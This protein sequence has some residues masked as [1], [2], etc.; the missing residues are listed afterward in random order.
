MSG[1]LVLEHNNKPHHFL[2]GGGEMGARMRSFDWTTTPLG[3]P[4]SWPQSLKTIIRVMLDSRY[5]MWMLWGAENTFFCNDAYL[6]TVGIRRDWVL[7]ARSDLVWEEV[8]SEVIVPRLERV[9]KYGEATWDEA[10]QLFL[11]RSGFSE[12]TYHT[13]SYSPIYDDDNRIAGMLCVVTEVTD[14]VIGERRLRVL[15]ELAAHTAAPET[16]ESN[17]ARVCR[18]LDN[19]RYDIAFSAIYL[20]EKNTNMARRV[21]LSNALEESVAPAALNADTQT[22]WPLEKLIATATAQECDLIAANISVRSPLWP[23][24]VKKALLVPFKDAGQSTLAGFILVG[25]SPRRPFDD[26]YHSFLELVAN[27]IGAAVAEA[28][29]YAAERRRLQALAELDRAKTAFF[30]NVS[31]EFRTPLT[32]MLSPVETLLSGSDISPEVRNQLELAHRNSLRL[33]KLVNSLLDFSRIEAGRVD[34]NF[35]ATDFTAFARDIASTFRSAIERAGLQFNVHCEELPQPVYIDRDMWEK[36]ILNLLSNAFKFTLQGSIEVRLSARENHALLEV[37]DTGVG[38]PAEELS[39]LF[40]RFYRVEK[41]QGRTHEGSGIGLALVRELVELHGAEIQVTSELGVGSVFRIA[42]PFGYRHLPSDKIV[43]AAQLSSAPHH[44]REFVEEALRW[45]P[46]AAVDPTVNDIDAVRADRR[47]EKTFGARI[48]VVD[49]NADMRAYMRTLLSPFY[50]V[51]TL[52]DGVEALASARRLRPDVILSDVMMPNL[53]GFGLLAELH[54]DNQLRDVPVILLSARA[55]EEARIEGFDAGADD[56]LAKPF[57]SREMLMCV[58]ALLE[59]THMRRDSES[60]LRGALLRSQTR[61]AQ[62]ETLLSEAPIGIFLL[63]SDLRF[64]EINPAGFA[65]FD[66][67]DLLIGS[68]FREVVRTQWEASQAEEIV[69]V[70]RHTLETGQP[71]YAPE[72]SDK[73]RDRGIVES[74]EWQIHRI[75]FVTGGFGVV[76]YFRNISA[77]VDAR[78]VLLEQQHLLQTAD[79]Q[80]DQFLAMLAHELRNPLAPIGNAT[81]L[82]AHLIDDDASAQS[83]IQMIKRQMIHL[84]RLV[85]DLLD[86]SR[87]TQ[88]RI[89]LQ[90]DTIDIAQV[91]A[92]AL[93]TVEP[94]L[95]A[96]GQTLVMRSTYASPM[97]VDGDVTRLVQCLVNILTN[98]IKYSDDVG[99]IAMNAYTDAGYAVIEVSDT[100]AGIPQDLLPHIYD[101]FVQGERTLDRAQGGLGIG[102]SVVKGLIEMHGGTIDAFSSGS[103]GGSTFTLKLPLSQKT[104]VHFSPQESLQ[105]SAK[106]IL[107][108]DDNVDAAQSLAVLLTLTGHITKTAND[109]REA[110]AQLDTFTPD[111]AILDIGLPQMDGYELAAAIRAL[112]NLQHLKLIALTGYG[113]ASDR[114]KAQRAGFNLHLVKPIEFDTLKKVLED[115]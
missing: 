77:H 3:S 91:I 52:S 50:K 108:V 67:V 15:S 31:H 83:A 37:V 39:R 53:D 110:L 9:L 35:E 73:R 65:A 61:E 85:D 70:F 45:L 55:G 104:D 34:A 99:E 44:A 92:Q 28:E 79:R 54:A 42:V 109:G 40:E 98:A 106:K 113:Q 8:W 97:R 69:R 102:L 6:P 94:L 62:F 72:L 32:L 111:I 24:A 51:E 5:A 49:D 59:L 48:L 66:D 78:R 27:Q 103:G 80:K 71:F 112:P 13:F 18:V 33:L 47:F 96:K 105:T 4:E 22:H 21:A 114:L 115:I 95:Q 86:V 29:A 57:S 93:E 107:V 30:S 75:P 12:E 25:I 64:R 60:R 90:I 38:I 58:G 41:T 20:I 46:D 26:A 68:D 74:Y 14:R 2:A 23:D 1:R 101:L 11:E 88:G 43:E 100:G 10:L 16:V 89:E 82:L 56:Y 19:Y 81:E 17:C 84:T 7:G 87:I 63:D 36:I 76:C